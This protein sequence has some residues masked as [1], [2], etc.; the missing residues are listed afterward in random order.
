MSKEE[1]TSLMIDREPRFR[2]NAKSKSE[3][4][5]P[6]RCGE[7]SK[8]DGNFLEKLEPKG[9]ILDFLADMY[10]R[11]Q[12]YRSRVTSTLTQLLNFDSWN[13]AADNDDD[14]SKDVVGGA[15]C[16]YAPW[17]EPHSAARQP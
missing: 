3:K 15:C 9:K 8:Q 4:C 17:Y 13:T 1:R 5:S 7:I 6:R 12:K 2:A 16:R 11:H 14:N 10:E